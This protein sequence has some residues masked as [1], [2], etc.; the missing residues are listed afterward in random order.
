M[1]ARF[2][3]PVQGMAMLVCAPGRPGGTLKPRLTGLARVV[4]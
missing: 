1:A 3:R 4:R 2:I